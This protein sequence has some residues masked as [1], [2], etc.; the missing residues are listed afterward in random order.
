MLFL[1]QEDGGGGG[2]IAGVFSLF[3]LALIVVMVVAN[4]KLFEKAGQPGWACIIPVYNLYVMLQ[5]AGMG[6]IWLLAFFIPFLNIIAMIMVYMRI[7]RAFGQ[8]ALVGVAMIFL[9][10]IIMPMLAFGDAQW[11][12]ID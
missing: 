9:P 10:F 8:S 5:V 7:A 4:W 12:P 11:R 6:A 3:F 2:L 1:A